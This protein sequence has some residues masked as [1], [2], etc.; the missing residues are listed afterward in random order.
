MESYQAGT[1]TNTCTSLVVGEEA[2]Y[3][4]VYVRIAWEKLATSIFLRG[5]L[6]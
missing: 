5:L 3:K 6:K 1:L 4:S 2:V